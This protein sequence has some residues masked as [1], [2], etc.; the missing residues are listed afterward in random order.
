M[1]L[2]LLHSA[3]PYTVY[4]ENFLFSFISVLLFQEKLSLVREFYQF[5]E[6]VV[7]LTLIKMAKDENDL[8]LLK[9][10]MLLNV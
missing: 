10:S 5:T 2:Q 3:F 9:G 8:V 7:S 1:T 6:Y 4:E